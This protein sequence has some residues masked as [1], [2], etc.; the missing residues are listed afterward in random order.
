MP[1]KH[2]GDIGFEIQKYAEK[3]NYSVVRDFC[4]HGIGKKFQNDNYLYPVKVANKLYM[5]GYRQ[6]RIVHYHDKKM[7]GQLN[8]RIF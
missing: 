7:I 5:G 3:K 1:G 8:A 2:L 6:H 4:G